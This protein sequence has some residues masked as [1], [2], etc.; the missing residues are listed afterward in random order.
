[1][2]ALSPE[3]VL[4]FACLE[5]YCGSISR[6]KRLELLGSLLAS[7]E[8]MAAEPVSLKRPADKEAKEIAL[9]WF[10]RELSALIAA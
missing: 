2:R 7:L 6:K 10:Q 9:A 5:S 8:E 1:M 4:L 3:A